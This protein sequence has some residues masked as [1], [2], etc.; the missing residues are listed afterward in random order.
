KVLSGSEKEKFLSDPGL[1]K[2]LDDEGISISVQK[3][4]SREIATRPDL[5]TFD[6]AYPAGAHAAVKIA[7]T[8]GSKRVFNTF[9]TPMAVASWKALVPVLENSGVVARKDGTLFIIN[10]SKLVDM[11]LKGT[12]WKDLPGNAAFP[13]GKSVLVSSTD[14]RKSNSGGM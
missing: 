13:V 14:V 1:A 2:I 5:K 9:Y 7:Q 4:G 10:M 6:A 12:R 11:M 3:S 8:T